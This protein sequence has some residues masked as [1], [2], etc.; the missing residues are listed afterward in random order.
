M[1]A[2]ILPLLS[3][4]RR[5]TPVNRRPGDERAQVSGI[6]RRARR[7]GREPRARYARAGRRHSPLDGP[8]SHAAWIDAGY[9]GGVREKVHEKAPQPMK[10]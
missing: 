9:P 1:D 4:A 7:Q 10:L 5:V 8:N 2:G 3:T 6:K